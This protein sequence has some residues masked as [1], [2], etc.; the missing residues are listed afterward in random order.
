MNTKS[1]IAQQLH[2]L[3]KRSNDVDVLAY[4][5]ILK[6]TNQ[7]KVGFSIDQTTAN[8]LIM[9]SESQPRSQARFWALPWMA[10]ASAILLMFFSWMWLSQSTVV[11]VAVPLASMHSVT[12]PDGSTVLL[13]A[14]SELSYDPY[15]WQEGVRQLSLS[16]KGYFEVKKGS[17]FKVITP[18]GY[19]TVLGTSFNVNTFNN[20]LK[21]ACFTGKVHATDHQGGAV[22][23][24]PG[25][26]VSTNKIGKLKAIRKV[27]VTLDQEWK[28][29]TFRY[30]N[31]EIDLVW[32]E[33]ERQFAIVVIDQTASARS[34]TGSFSN[35]NI[36]TALRNIC[37]PMGLN[38]QLSNDTIRIK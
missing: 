5:R 32:K 26:K 27:D 34:Y 37:L 23:L 28:Y 6:L 9:R 19:V 8:E 2:T 15:Q 33:I 29:G 12:L 21:V 7:W 36:D 31:E 14:G 4:S 24:L 18:L 10:A 3:I 35:K 1:S 13:N 25:D 30:Q 17:N 11:R 20:H 22:I 38:Y 16:G